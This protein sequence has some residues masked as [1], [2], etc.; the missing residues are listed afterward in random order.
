MRSPF[1]RSSTDVALG[2]LLLFCTL[3]TPGCT[4]NPVAPDPLGSWGG[5]GIHLIVTSV[6]SEFELDCAHAAMGPL[7]T[8]R[9]GSFTASG[10]LV[11]EGGPE[12]EGVPRETRDVVFGGSVAGDRM[13]AT[14]RFVDAGFVSGPYDLRRGE[15]G[16]LRKCL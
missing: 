2:T 11:I 16:L 15:Q 5:V 13:T 6:G 9:N 14:I 12:R 7:R 3:G 1:H 10:D 8:E 4:T